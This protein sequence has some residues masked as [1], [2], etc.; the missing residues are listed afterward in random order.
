MSITRV[1]IGKAKHIRIPRGIHRIPTKAEAVVAV[2][3]V[4]EVTQHHLFTRFH[5]VLN[6][7]LD[8][9]PVLLMAGRIEHDIRIG[10]VPGQLFKLVRVDVIQVADKLIGFPVKENVAAA[11][12]VIFIELAI[13]EKHQGLIRVP[14]RHGGVGGFGDIRCLCDPN[15]AGAEFRVSDTLQITGFIQLRH[16]VIAF[17][18]DQAG[19]KTGQ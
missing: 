5:I 12:R 2:D 13:P 9:L 18:G 6:E 3:H 19:A 10:C 4:T 17:I 1:G 7:M 15:D 8:A 16:G 11:I 14:D